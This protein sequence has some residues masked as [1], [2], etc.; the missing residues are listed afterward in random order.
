MIFYTSKKSP[1]I[2]AFNLLLFFVTKLAFSQGNTPCTAV[3]VT[4]NSGICSPY[5]SGTIAGSATY[6][7]NAANGGTPSCA[8]TFDPDVWYSFLAPTSGLIV[9]TTNAGSI[10]NSGMELYSS[11]TNL[12]TGTLTSIDCNDDGGPGLMSELKVCG[13]VVGNRYFLRLWNKGAGSTGTFSICFYYETSIPAANTNCAGALTVCSDAAFSGNSAG[14]GVQEVGTC[15]RGCL[16]TGEHQSSWYYFTT[17]TAGNVNLNITPSVAT[18]DYDFAI[19]GPYTVSTI[20]CP[21]T[22]EPLRCSYTI[23]SGTGATGVSS[24][25]NAPATD[26]TEGTGGNQW[27]QT[28]AANAGDTYILLVDNY[29][30]S[31]QP[32]TLD[33]TVSAGATLGCTPL[34]ISLVSFEANLSL[35]KVQLKWTTASETNNDYFTI[36]K[37]KDAVNFEDLIQVEG[38]G[39]STSIINYLEFDSSPYNGLSYYRL[40]QT[41]FNGDVSYSNN[42]SVEYNPKLE[43]N[44]ELFPNPTDENSTTY[45]QLNHF[46]EQ[47]VLVVVRDILGKE[48]FSKVLNIKSKNE[49][50]PINQIGD[51]PKGAYL[52]SASGNNKTH[53]KLLIIK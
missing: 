4:V 53:S 15:N 45:M 28:I 22:G 32:F 41:D 19:W 25:N 9:I 1:W 20:P 51:L 17:T 34:P 5:I 6:Q 52:I 16:N 33:W 37:S 7:F 26:L 47:N 18:D 30:V 8:N 24:T 36:Q 46:D 38:A 29:A 3:S 39:N 11:S 48:L 12:C 10:T 31:F 23:V 44:I 13:L 35:D 14:A 2:I 50:F 27:V 40:A 49:L 42:V 21:P 43:S